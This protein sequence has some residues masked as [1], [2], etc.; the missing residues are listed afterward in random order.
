MSHQLYKSRK[1]LIRLAYL[2][3]LFIIFNTLLGCSDQSATPITQPPENCDLTSQNQYVFDLMKDFYFWYQQVPEVDPAQFSS[4]EA[5]LASLIY[6][7]LD[8][9]SG[10]SDQQTYNMFLGQG[11]FIGI[12]LRLQSDDAGRLF[13]ALSY[14]DSPAAN[15][16]IVRGTEIIAING[17]MVSSLV[18]GDDYTNAWGDT[19][20]GTTATLEILLP[21]ASVTSSVTMTREVVTIESTPIVN[22]FADV[23]GVK[24]GY[25][26]FTNFFGG[27]TSTTP[28]SNA[29]ALFQNENIEQLILDLRYNG[30]GAVQT[31]VH[32]GSLIGGQI[33]EDT[34]FSRLI[35]SDRYSHFNSNSYFSKKVES[36]AL[37]KIY[38]I[39]T[40]ATCSASEMLIN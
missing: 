1:A 23:N 4:P 34:V 20:S 38:I 36:L 35:Y 10:I 39:T 11:Q 3:L 2:G 21:G 15:A 37:N 5:L 13:V 18:T 22:T 40:A 6:S 7:P 29:F 19:S 8:R 9:F 17:N 31:A 24:F 33:A 16:G 14:S 26:L 30:G 32:L 28:L 12:G 27:S 25:L